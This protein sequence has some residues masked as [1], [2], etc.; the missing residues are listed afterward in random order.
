MR[1]KITLKK[2]VFG[3]ILL[4]GAITSYG[5]VVT[6]SA[7]DGTAGTLRNQI[8]SASADNQ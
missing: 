1:K 8:A 4:F 7:D 3:L 6:S 2:L 5:Q